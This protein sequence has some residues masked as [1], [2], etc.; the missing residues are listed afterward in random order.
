VP[1]RLQAGQEVEVRVEYHPDV[2]RREAGFVTKRLGIAPELEQVWL[3]GQAFGEALAEC[4]VGAVEPGGRLPVSVPRT[5]AESPA[6]HAHPETGELTYTEGLLMGYRGYE[7]D[8]VEPLFCFGHGLAYTDWS[9]SGWR[10]RLSRSR[11]ART[12][13][14]W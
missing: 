4:L 12:F 14:W 7:R 1:V 8:G 3:P 13:P 2:R 10:R 6:L 9:Y 11:P 5:E